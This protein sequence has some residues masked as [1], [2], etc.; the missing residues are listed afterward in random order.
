MRTTH[1]FLRITA[2]AA[3]VGSRRKPTKPGSIRRIRGTE[4]N[5]RVDVPRTPALPR[6]IDRRVKGIPR[7]PRCRDRSQQPAAERSEREA[8]LRA[9]FPALRGSVQVNPR[10]ARRTHQASVAGPGAG[11]AVRPRQQ[12]SSPVASGSSVMSQNG[13]TGCAPKTIR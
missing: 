4:E 8:A 3:A 6:Q 10:P 2:V 11:M 13:T 1:R 9:R 12:R 5:K 7:A